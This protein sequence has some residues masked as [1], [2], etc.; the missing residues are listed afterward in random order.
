MNDTARLGPFL[1]DQGRVRQWPVKRA[2]Q[3]TLLRRMAEAFEPG[4]RYTE[5]EVNARLNELHTFGDWALLRRE[6]C[7]L[8]LLAREPDG[9][10]YWRVPAEHAA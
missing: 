8:H 1:D 4:R 9:S 5:K 10:A 7:D 2:K 3:L 6:L